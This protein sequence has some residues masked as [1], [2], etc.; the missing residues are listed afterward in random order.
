MDH[1]QAGF[2]EGKV[3]LLLGCTHD[4]LRFLVVAVLEV[5]ITPARLAITLRGG[6]RW[7]RKF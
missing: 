5:G 7:R 3:R 6:C 2:D 1:H 4:G